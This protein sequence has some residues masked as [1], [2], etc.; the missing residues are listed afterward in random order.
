[1]SIVISS[2]MTSKA[3]WC[4]NEIEFKKRRD[5]L[6]R[7]TVRL[8]WSEEEKFW[9]SES[10]DERF[11]LTLESGSLDALIERV[12]IAVPD[13]YE[14]IGYK[15]EINLSFEIERTDKLGLAAS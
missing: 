11:G 9:H 6:M 3:D 15:G 7:C 1:M 8:I 4:E 5:I 10:L 13:M 12:R 14:L 2:F